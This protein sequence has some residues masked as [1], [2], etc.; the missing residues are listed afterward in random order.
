MIHVPLDFPFPSEEEVAEGK[1]KAEEK[2]RE[3]A[4]AAE[5]EERRRKRMEFRE[6]RPKTRSTVPSSR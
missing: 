2:R 3:A 6:T 1:R 5:E 4:K